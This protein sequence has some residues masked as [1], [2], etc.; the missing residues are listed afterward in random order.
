MINNTEKSEFDR[1]GPILTQSPK[2]RR[3]RKRIWIILKVQLS[4][5]R[6]MKKFITQYQFK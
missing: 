6:R 1:I 2:I 4:I 3:K 5:L